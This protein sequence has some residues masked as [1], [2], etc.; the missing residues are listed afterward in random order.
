MACPDTRDSDSDFDVDDGE[1]RD[2]SFE[3]ESDGGAELRPSA[4]EP[5]YG[6]SC[7]MFEPKAR[8]SNA[9]CDDNGEDPTREHSENSVQRLDNLDW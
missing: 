7:Y 2:S 4:M 5:V 1:C 9:E 6:G 8:S 3:Y